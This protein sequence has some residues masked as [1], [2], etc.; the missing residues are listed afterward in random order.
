MQQPFFPAH[1][2]FERR[3]FLICDGSLCII[4][5]QDLN[6]API[7]IDLAS[8][9]FDHDFSFDDKLIDAALSKHIGMNALNFTSEEL[10]HSILVATKIECFNS[11]DVKFKAF[12]PMCLL[13][14]ASINLSSKLKS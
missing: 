12:I 7:G 2:D 5:H 14:A 13:N 8:L 11:S 10:K 1:N 9:L 6:I 3:N 4:D